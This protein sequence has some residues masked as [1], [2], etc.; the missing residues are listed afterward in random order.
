MI[1]RP[2]VLFLLGLA[3]TLSLSRIPGNPILGVVLVD[4]EVQQDSL[5]RMYW[6]ESD[7]PPRTALITGGRRATLEFPLPPTRMYRLRIDPTQS[8]N[9][10]VVIYRVSIRLNEAPEINIP[11]ESLAQWS[12]INT[13]RPAVVD[14]SLKYQSTSRDAYFF[15]P[16]SLPAVSWLVKLASFGRDELRS[17]EFLAQVI[18]LGTI[19]AYL[20]WLKSE[21][22][23]VHALLIGILFCSAY[24]GLSVLSAILRPDVYDV[25]N[26]VGHAA[27]KGHS[28]SPSQWVTALAGLIAAALGFVCGSW[29]PKDKGVTAVSDDHSTNP[30]RLYTIGEKSIAVGWTLTLVLVLMP[31][32]NAIAQS[33]LSGGFVPHWDA[34]NI[35]TWAGFIAEGKRPYL[36]F[37]FPYGG[38]WIFDLP[39]PLGPLLQR[40]YDVALYGTLGMAVWRLVGKR[41]G[42]FFF[43]M[44]FIVLLGEAEV[45]VARHRYLLSVSVVLAFV[46]IDHAA[47]FLSSGRIWFGIACALALWSEPAQLVYA[48]P[49][50]GIAQIYVEMQIKDTTVISRLARACKTFAIPTGCLVSLLLFFTWR[51]ELSGFI[52]TSLENASS[53]IYGM[54]PT[55][56][57]HEFHHLLSITTIGVFAPWVLS[58]IG[59]FCVVARP[60]AGDRTLALAVL[61]MSVVGIMITQKHLIRP[62]GAQLLAPSIIGALLLLFLFRTQLR[63]QAVVALILGSLTACTVLNA[64]MFN[65][66]RSAVLGAYARAASTYQVLVYQPMLLEAANRKAFSGDRFSEFKQERAIVDSLR[67]TKKKSLF[68]LGDLPILYLFSPG[69]TPFHVN[70]YNASPIRAQNNLRTWLGRTKPEVVIVD[71]N[72]LT[73]DDIQLVVRIPIVAQW[74][75]LN[76]V[77]YDRVGRYPLLARRLPNQPIDLAFWQGLLGNRVN[78]GHLL[79][80]SRAARLQ[81][82]SPTMADESCLRYLE[83]TFASERIRAA[84]LVEMPID[85]GKVEF[86]VSFVRIPGQQTYLVPIDR[87]WFWT[88]GEE[89]GLA[90][91][92]RADGAVATAIISKR[93]NAPMLY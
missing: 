19:V 15:G 35:I 1:A 21:H 27:F 85:V 78:Y 37:W 4:L 48:A 17:N 63:S 79:Q 58:F 51:G 57:R 65:V 71:P 92:P 29:A 28:I 50:V 40:A 22:A 64:Q 83:V 11:L 25:S 44:A 60:A 73:F 88:A 5:V 8:S 38:F 34:N 13:T 93:T 77:P 82:C 67:S 18:I 39:L 91:R 76:Y 45:L 16:V 2:I 31:D 55:S 62:I 72:Q 30:M 20:L 41:L 90:P 36:D 12:F 75:I 81:V 68:V 23:I 89:M 74:V 84:T 56:L 26:A 14:G 46:A 66:F 53:V 9:E 6:N 42:V 59:A 70:H 86:L 43:L 24:W 87:L 47:P 33:R 69:P 80:H 52:A 10:T 32:L 7:D 61:C 49:A 54:L 3:V